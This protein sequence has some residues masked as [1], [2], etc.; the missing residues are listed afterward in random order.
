MVDGG[1]PRETLRKIREFYPVALHG[2]SMSLGSVDGVDADYLRRLKA[3]VDEVDPMVV[4]DH[5]CWTRTGGFN[6]HDLLPVPYTRDALDVVCDNLNRAQDALG[7]SLLVENPSSYVTFVEAEMHEWEFLADLCLRTGCGLLLD[8]NNVYVSACNHG[9]EAIDYVAGTPLQ[10]VHQVHLAGH[11]RGSNLL[12][13]TH[14]QPIADPVW[15]LFQT[16]IPK[17]SGAAVMIERDDN[18]PPLTDLLNELAIARSIAAE[19]C[20]LWA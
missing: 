12:I 8:V 16:I 11:T 7:R 20:R 2:V 17:L 1:R 15:D 13:D 10:H 3:L 4:S 14:D 9:F 19:G 6:S 5:L 18:I